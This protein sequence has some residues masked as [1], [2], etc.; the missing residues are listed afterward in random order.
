MEH[1]PIGTTDSYNQ[2]FDLS[3]AAQMRHT[4]IFGKSGVG[5]ST[6]MRNMIAWD[7]SE[8]VGLALADPHGDLVDDLL[9]MIPRPRTNDVIY[10]NPHDPERVPGINPLRKVSD[11]QKPLVVSSIISILKNIWKDFWG[12]QTE[13]ILSN[14]VAA[15]L[16]QKRPVTFRIADYSSRTDL[17][18][19]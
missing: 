5:K 18:L 9:T 12:P 4:A 11:A 15:L 17:L 1:L 8:G 10:F 6:L 16:E 19:R 3:P 7:I 13:Y 2:L 14:L